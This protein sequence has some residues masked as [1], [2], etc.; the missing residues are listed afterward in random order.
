MCLKSYV[1]SETLLVVLQDMG[2]IYDWNRNLLLAFLE[3]VTFLPITLL[4]LKVLCILFKWILNIYSV[5]VW[6]FILLG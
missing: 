2:I 1:N 4:F 3:L 6:I 5:H